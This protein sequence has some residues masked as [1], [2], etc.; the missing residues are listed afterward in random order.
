MRIFLV[1]LLT[2]FLLYACGRKTVALQNAKTSSFIVLGSCEMC[3]KRIE[4]VYDKAGISKA[5]WEDDTQL[6][7]ITYDAKLFSEDQL[8]KMAAIVGHDTKIYKAD[9]KVYNALPGCCKYDRHRS[10]N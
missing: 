2:A 6:V 4:S 9:D 10:F 7:T 3:E 1:G 8:Q 5:D